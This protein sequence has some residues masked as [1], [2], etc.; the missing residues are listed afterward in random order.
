MVQFKLLLNN[1]TAKQYKIYPNEVRVLTIAATQHS[2][3]V[4]ELKTI[5]GMA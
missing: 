1:K 5:I 3:K 4:P 2:L